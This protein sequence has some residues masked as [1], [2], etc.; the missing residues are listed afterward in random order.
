MT[1]MTFHSWKIMWVILLIGHGVH[2]LN[3]M[4][5]GHS[6]KDVGQLGLLRECK[7]GRTKSHTGL[8]Q[9]FFGWF[10]ICVHIQPLLW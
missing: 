10:E 9:R 6:V 4:M 8:F 1:W 5:Y 2:I 7:P 3:R